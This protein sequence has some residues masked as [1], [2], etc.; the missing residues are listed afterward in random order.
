VTQRQDQ[1]STLGQR[2]AYE[3]QTAAHQTEVEG[4]KKVK[5]MEVAAGKKV[6]ADQVEAA[7]KVHDDTVKA[8]EADSANV[9]DPD[10]KYI[11]DE[12]VK[13]VKE[14]AAIKLNKVKEASNDGQ[15]KIDDAAALE[16][17]RINEEIDVA[18]R[19]RNDA[20]RKTLEAERDAILSE[21][22]KIVYS[23]QLNFI[24]RREKEASSQ[25]GRIRGSLNAIGGAG[26]G[27]GTVGLGILGMGAILPAMAAAMAINAKG[28][29]TQASMDNLIKQYGTDGRKASQAKEKKENYSILADQIAESNKD[30]TPKS[31]K[32]K[33]GD[34]ETK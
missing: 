1:N 23:R 10:L 15:K 26:V 29:Q 34:D 33:G 7:Q 18:K 25:G 3:N 6:H 32:A 24:K 8:A 4:T 30:I 31:S 9:T 20:K 22:S 21:E 17:A 11:E 2:L 12:K 27:L 19:A 5:E 13:K 28:A 16:L 14:A